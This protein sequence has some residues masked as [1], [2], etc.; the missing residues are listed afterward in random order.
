MGSLISFS[1]SSWYTHSP[2]ASLPVSSE[3]SWAGYVEE[4]GVF[5]FFQCLI[6]L[7]CSICI[8][9]GILSPF[10]LVS[11]YL[12]CSPWKFLLLLFLSFFFFIQHLFEILFYSFSL[13]VEEF[14]LCLHFLLLCN[15]CFVLLICMCCVSWDLFIINCRASHFHNIITNIWGIFFQFILFSHPPIYSYFSSRR[16]CGWRCSRVSASHVLYKASALPALF[17]R[18]LVGGEEESIQINVRGERVLRVMALW[19]GEQPGY[20]GSLMR[21]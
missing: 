1:I 7:T 15:W 2:S 6:S 18:I 3:S 17:F 20:R 21:S 16:D 10:S 14:L 9:I 5:V 11:A 12:W 19:G 8:I 13:F 4:G